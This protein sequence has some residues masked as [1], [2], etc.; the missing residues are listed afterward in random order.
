M[1]PKARRHFRWLLIALLA[2]LLSLLFSGCAESEAKDR[3]GADFDGYVK[4]YNRYINGW[5]QQQ[6]TAQ[7]K[8]LTEVTE[9]IDAEADAEVKANLVKKRADIESE[10]GR[11]KDRQ[12]L[13]D[14][15]QFKTPEDV[16]EG[17][18][19]EDGMEQPEI[20]DARATKGGAFRY[21]IPA[22]P[23]TIRPFGRGSNNSFRG[24]LYDN[25]ELGLVDLHPATGELI[26][27]VAKEWA[28]ADDKRTVYFKLDPDAKYND[29]VDIKAIDFLWAVY[30]RTSDNVVSA[31]FSQYMREQFANFTTY[32]D[33]ILSISLPTPKPFLPYWCSLYPSAP[34]FYKDYG[35]DYEDEY[36]WK[37]PP[38]TAAY[39]IRDGGIK[40]G[41]SITLTRVDDWWAKDKKFYR[42]RFNADN[43]VYLVVRDL[44]KAWELFRAGELDY[45]PVTLPDYWYEKSE[46]PP[47]FKGYVER[48]TWYNQYPRV[49]WSLYLN[50]AKAPLNDLNVR[51]GMA[52]AT[53]WQKVIDVVFRGDAS[54]L[55]GWSKGYGDFD[56]PDITARPFSVSKAREYFAKAGYTED[57]PNGILRNAAGQP[58]EIIISYTST[59]IRKQMMTI[60]EEEAAKAGLDLVL[61]GLDGTRAYNKSKNKEHMATFTGWGFR[62]PQ[63]RFFEYF[64]SRNAYDEKGNIRKDTNNIFSY[65]DDRMDRLSIAYRFGTDVK[66]LVRLAH[67][68]QQII[69]DSGVYIPG[70][71]TEFARV[72][73]WRWVRW[74]DSEDTEFA[75]PRVYIPMESYAYWIDEDMQAETRAAMR[76]GK[77]FP[78]V[79][80]VKDRYRTR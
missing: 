40:K 72:A 19:W 41:A 67:E 10:L 32:G 73:C 78:E 3:P 53:N 71:M 58:L 55:P 2:P 36:R 69:Y 24:E 13:G 64:H 44:S 18:V 59:A 1:N 66:E 9:E 8:A 33:D 34:H 56:D 16:P 37:V 7:E 48:Y 23:P 31:F 25:V 63:P 57:G 47:V 42:H 65:K 75:P 11:V 74:P 77:T 76:S 29:G 22:F 20:G 30:V 17:L 60:L 43:L 49:P 35:P 12:K 26:P 62:P 50:T 15:F 51:L 28:I 14:Y 38:T 46:M 27:G 70:Y 5:L 21:F 6:L 79:Q 61:D 52:Y 80:E 68:M 54:R 4:I 45:F 39:T